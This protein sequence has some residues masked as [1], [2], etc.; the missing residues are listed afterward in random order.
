[1]SRGRPGIEG[2]GLRGKKMK[3]AVCT[4]CGRNGQSATPEFY[5]CGVCYYAARAAFDLAKV[6]ELEHVIARIRTR[7]KY[8]Q[9]RSDHLLKKWG[10]P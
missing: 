2:A 4:G 7:A 3:P 5:R 8:A 9:E 6:D 10:P 1:M